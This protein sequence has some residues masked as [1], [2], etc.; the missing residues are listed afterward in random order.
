MTRQTAPTPAIFAR[1][2]V[3]LARIDEK[4]ADINTLRWQA[5][6]ELTR[7]HEAGVTIDQLA[8]QLNRKPKDIR[9][10]LTAWKCYGG[11]AKIREEQTFGGL[12]R[13]TSRY[14][15]DPTQ[16]QVIIDQARREGRSVSTVMD[17]AGYRGGNGPG[18]GRTGGSR[19]PTDPFIKQLLALGAPVEIQEAWYGLDTV[20]HNLRRMGESEAVIGVEVVAMFESRLSTINHQLSKIRTTSELAE[21]ARGEG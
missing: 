2:Q 4:S 7:V 5:A 12:A 18:G 20:L 13:L 17:H 9:D 15:D 10:Y 6:E 16:R 8:E 14:P 19:K 1:A 3:L 11:D 21:M